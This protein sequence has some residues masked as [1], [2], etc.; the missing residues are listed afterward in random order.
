MKRQISGLLLVLLLILPL[1]SGCGSK[2]NYFYYDIQSAPVNLDPQSA[3][4]Y[5]SQ[6]IISN[7][8]QGLMR[9][10][11]EGELV[12]AAA[13]HYQVADGGMTYRFTLREDGYW[14]D[15]T[16]VVAEDFVYA[17]RRLFNPDTNAPM[18]SQFFCIENGEEVLAE[19]LPPESLGVEALDD[20]L[21]EIRLST[22]NARF[23]YLLT[24]APA[25]PC[26]ETFFTGTRGKYG[27][28]L[29]QI[30]GNGPFYLSSWTDASVRLQHSETYADP[31]VTAQSVTF[32]VL[33][34]MENPDT[35]VNRFLDGRT[36]G[37]AVADLDM[38]EGYSNYTTSE[39]TVWGMIFQMEDTPFAQ[40]AIRQALLLDLDLSG[41]G[42]ELP[43]GASLARAIV[44]SHIRL[45]EESYRTQAG[46]DLL[47]SQNTAEAQR[48]Y[49]EGLDALGVSQLQ[50]LSIIM[51]EGS[52]HEVA[53]GYLSQIWQRDFQLYLTV[54]VLPETEYRQRLE[55]GEFDC[56]L[57]ALTGSYNS[58]H[59][60]L[61]QFGSRSAGNVGNFKSGELDSLL[62][63]AETQSD[64]GKALALYRQAEEL[65][66][67]EAAFLPFYYQAQYFVTADSV[68]GIVYDFDSRI[69]SFQYGQQN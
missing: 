15:G 18:V 35:P 41:A 8:F 43:A 5:S 6:L 66:I 67:E 39:N 42:E 46:D 3:A 68:T 32:N 31:A 40:K 7:L 54:E 61:E 50:G 2:G 49:R 16:P 19:Q 17:F 55:S 21:L 47:P 53:F 29:G 45:G 33:D 64:P 44:P 26:N 65:L 13:E 48:L 62:A 37:V 23:L 12:P 34:G 14:S 58:P 11:E 22:Y 28:S 52:G 36:S 63:Q 24:T 38:V 20:N 60:V 10:D 57:V 27:L 30:M 1:L 51:P 69:V 9:V 56:A 4:D 25:M 59:A